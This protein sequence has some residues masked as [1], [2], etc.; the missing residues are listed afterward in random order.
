MIELDLEL[1]KTGTILIRGARQLLTLRSPKG[2]RR[3]S[4]LNQL[5]IIPEGAVL[6]R[7]GVLI[8]VGS[9]RRLENVNEARGAF[10]INA[11]GRVVMPGFVDSHTHLLTPPPGSPDSDPETAVRTIRTSTVKR[12]TARTRNHL[13]SMA[14]HG[15]TT[16]EAKTGCGPDERAEIKLFRVLA[17]LKKDLVD[18]VPTVLLRMPDVARADTTAADA[19]VDW[20][21]R[22]LLP[23]VRQRKLARFV[24]LEW[25]GDPRVHTCFQR[26]LQAA[27]GLGFGR[28]MHADKEQPEAAIAMATQNLAVSVDH[29][30]HATDGDLANLAG[31]K[32]IATLLP[33]P[34]FQRRGLSAPARSLIEAGVPVALASDFNPRHTPNLN[35]Q[36]VVALACLQMGLTVAEA[37]SAATI[38]GAHAL[39]CADRVGS[40]E[41]GKQ[42]DLLILNTGDYRELEHHFGM[43]LVH[44]TMKRGEF[45]YKEGEVAKRRIEELRPAGF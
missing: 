14:R 34:C 1:K 2:A 22:E 29:L 42:A 37:I 13:H 41:P 27:S 20:Y 24:D 17:A 6:I 3:G 10:E 44:L 25:E 5:E 21:T 39:H 45:I 28:K 8:E 32:T 23:K 26:Y 35:M 18:V 7:D 43:N 9:S 30:E 12:L 40:L 19:V 11:A 38:N 16:V 33:F 4:E 36:T 31:G 15:T